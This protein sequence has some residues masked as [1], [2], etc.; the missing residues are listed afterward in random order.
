MRRVE[1]LQIIEKA[2]ECIPGFFIELNGAG[3][4]CLPAGQSEF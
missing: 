4:R 3:F 1:E 2:W